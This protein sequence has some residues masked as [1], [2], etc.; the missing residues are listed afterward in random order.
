MIHIA[1]FE[2]T[3]HLMHQAGQRLGVGGLLYFYGPFHQNDRPTAPSNLQFDASL[4]KRNPAWGIRDLDTV[5]AEA[6][7][8]GLVLDQITEMPANNLSVAFRRRPA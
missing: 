8:Q 2:A 7:S 4:R 1:P 6:E 3:E 5:A